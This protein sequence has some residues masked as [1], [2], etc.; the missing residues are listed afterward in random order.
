ML[1]RLLAR[2]APLS[3]I[4]QDNEK[5][6]QSGTITY[7]S[8]QFPVHAACNNAS[9]KGLPNQTNKRHVYS[10]AVSDDTTTPPLLVQNVQKGKD[11]EPEKPGPH[12]RASETHI[13]IAQQKHT[14][15]VFMTG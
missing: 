1:A 7:I 2:S 11:K 13:R 3:S 14:T 10:H 15:K 6:W 9:S 8:N 4:R 12:T 5:A